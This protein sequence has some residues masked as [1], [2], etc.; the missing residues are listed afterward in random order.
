VRAMEQAKRASPALVRSDMGLTRWLKKLPSAETVRP[1]HCPHCGAASRPIGKVVVVQ[2]HGVRSRQVRGPAAPGGPPLLQEVQVRR[3]R[4]QACAGTCTVAPW[5]VVARRLYA[6]TAVAWALALW[7]L[8]GLSLGAV[9]QQVSP[10][11]TVGASTSGG[12][13]HGTRMAGRG[14]AGPAFEQGAPKRPRAE[15]APSRRPRGPRC[16]Q[17]RLAVRRGPAAVRSGFL[18]SRPRRLRAMA[19]RREPRNCPPDTSP[20]PLGFRPGTLKVCLP[21]GFC[22][23]TSRQRR[24]RPFAQARP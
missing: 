15:P 17:L 3:Y 4:C 21:S 24:S 13:A 7:A 14:A 19:L 22:L 1:S 2:G 9:R 23:L 16:H 10:W 12:L 20:S 8:A 18:R 6:V 5:E 11:A